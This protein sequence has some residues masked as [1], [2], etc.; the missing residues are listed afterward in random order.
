MP[1][2]AHLKRGF[3][4]H[5]LIQSPCGVYTRG[6][7]SA[8][9]VDPASVGKAREGAPSR[10]SEVL[11]SGVRAV[12]HHNLGAYPWSYRQNLRSGVQKYGRP[13]VAQCALLWL[14]SC[15]LFVWSRMPPPGCSGSCLSGLESC[16]H[17][18]RNWLCQIG[19]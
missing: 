14:L 5:F 4:V 13:G 7:S 19:A 9:W 16:E 11:L 12:G 17:L 2:N 18:C 3:L 15:N 8:A 10:S 6:R 1:E